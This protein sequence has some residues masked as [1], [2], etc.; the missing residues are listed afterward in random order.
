MEK[1][2]GSRNLFY[3]LRCLISIT[4]SEKIE[5]ENKDQNEKLGGEGGSQNS[6]TPPQH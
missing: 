5:V 1:S 2:I 3:I 6:L 4:L